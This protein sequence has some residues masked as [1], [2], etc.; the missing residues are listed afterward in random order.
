MNM[1]S[2]YLRNTCR[3][4]DGTKLD[5]VLG[6][7]PSVPV[8]NY[9]PRL[10]RSVDCR[11]Y[12]M[13]LYL[14]RS[15]GHAQLL[16]VVAPEVLFGDY[17]YTSSSSPG[18]EA[19]FR[20]FVAS[21]FSAIGEVKAEDLVIDVGCNDGLLLGIIRERG[22]RTLG[23]DPSGFALAAAREKGLETFE[24]FLT[25][26]SADAIVARH[27]QAA[28]V[29]ATN[30]FSHADDMNEFAQAANRLLKPNGHFV[31]EVSYLKNLVFSGVWD[32]VYHEHLAHHSVKPL[33][34]FLR[35]LGFEL[36]S[37]Q[38]VPVKGGSLRCLARKVSAA[39]APNARIAELIVEEELLGLYDLSTYQ[40]L[41]RH[42]QSLRTLT[43]RVLDAL[44]RKA[45]IASY[46]ASA[47]CT[48]LSQELGYGHR[49]A[50]VVD[51]NQARQQTLSPGFLAP[52]LS[53]DDMERLKPALLIISAW[54]FCAGILSRCETYLQQGGVI[55]VPLPVPRL[56][57][58]L[59]EVMLELPQSSH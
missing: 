40:R 7:S 41:E 10:H 13:D 35:R 58:K 44:P 4:C 12:G 5:K 33:D 9:R 37:A 53:R 46:G 54:R 59:G 31:F 39:R 19:H 15:C 14:C 27:G 43:A 6:F 28:L 45:A 23:V 48:V 17:I 16:D 32:Y 56:I 38:Q 42:R 3:L 51:D 21:V 52:V 29:T 8:D 22:C 49:I 26:Q 55:Y 18:L 1:E 11:T 34:S 25:T 47:T 57:T 2:T 24:S 36:L 50:F 30:V 20:G